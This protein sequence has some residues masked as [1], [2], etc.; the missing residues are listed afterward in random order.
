[1]SIIAEGFNIGNMNLSSKYCLT[2]EEIEKIGE[3]EGYPDVFPIW[4]T[5]EDA[6]YIFYRTTDGV[7][8]IAKIVKN[9]FIVLAFTNQHV[10]NKIIIYQII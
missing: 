3:G 7:P 8:N 2:R 10:I 1:M 9:Y 4:C 5:D 6:L